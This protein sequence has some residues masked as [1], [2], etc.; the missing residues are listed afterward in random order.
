[1]YPF[2]ASLAITSADNPSVYP[3]IYIMSREEYYAITNPTMATS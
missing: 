3:I 1:M 2:K